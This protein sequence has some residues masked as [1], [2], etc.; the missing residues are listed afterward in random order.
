MAIDVR[1]VSVEAGITALGFR[2]LA[3]FARKLNPSTKLY[4]IPVSN[5]YSLMSHIFPS[6]QSKFSSRD[7]ESIAEELV[8][9][10]IICFSSM[11]AS[12]QYVEGIIAALR[13]KHTTAFILWGG[14]HCIVYPDEA[15]KHSDAICTGEGELPFEIFY[16]LFASGKDYTSTPGMWFRGSDT[17]RKNAYSQLNT[18]SHMEKF[19]YLYMGFDC[20]IY[21]LSKHRFRG[22]TKFDYMQFH[23]L[24][25]R[26]IWS[27]GCPYKCVYCAN[28]SFLSLNKD[29]GKIRY[30]SVDYMIEEI[31][32]ALKIHPYICT[33]AF[34]DDNFISIPSETLGNFGEEYKKRINKP[35]VVFGIHPN[36]ITAEKVEI[37][38]KAGMNR[39][40]MGIQSGSAKTLTFYN[41]PTPPGRIAEAT[42][43]LA[44]ATKKYKMIPPA[45]DIIS[46]NPVETRENIV[47]TLKFIY[48][49]ERPFTLTVFSLRVFPKTRLW[50]Y[51][52]EHPEIDIRKNLS[53]YL[54]TRKTMANII[55][56]MLG[57]FKPPKN[58]FF[59]LLKYVKA[60]NEPQKEYPI[61]HLLIK[62]T[63]LLS[64]GIEHIRKL[65]FTVIVG[66]WTYYIYGVR[67]LIRRYILQ[68]NS[69]LG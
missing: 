24:A 10:D 26:T 57:V 56:Y 20:S 66:R 7:I 31:E 43:I 63:Y 62:N 9:A 36:T 19:P 30:P 15:I 39:T 3:S 50:D 1:L 23:G 16:H 41:R 28:D 2:R 17:I 33:I 22:C 69:L 18:S 64:R 12:A 4:F 42:S 45:Y 48:D 51:F 38:A 54:E 46:D 34:Y 6:L 14:V 21:D 58:L 52:R 5:L 68:N 49:I 25:Y 59:W 67:G 32:H 53:S 8:S 40:R 11:T 29:Y 44:K 60:T 55:L 27:V 61:L 47:E 13:K 65:D 37:L 35:F